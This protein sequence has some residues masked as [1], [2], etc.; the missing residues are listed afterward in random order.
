MKQIELLFLGRTVSF[1]E[2]IEGNHPW[3]VANF[4]E[5][6]HDSEK[7]GMNSWLLLGPSKPDTRIYYY[8]FK[9]I[10]I[11]FVIFAGMAVI[12]CYLLF[13]IRSP[14][15]CA[16]HPLA[17][18]IPAGA[19]WTKTPPWH[20]GWWV[21]RSTCTREMVTSPADISIPQWYLKMPM[22]FMHVPRSC[23]PFLVK[24]VKIWESPGNGLGFYIACFCY[25][26]LYIR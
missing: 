19:T 12:C 7:W 17:D 25:V 13:Y 15:S 3:K 11:N 18:P 22:V 8:M 21:D 16:L 10:I 24:H 23:G 2:C 9:W 4:M 20:H 1:R 6:F 14:P 26:V 5:E